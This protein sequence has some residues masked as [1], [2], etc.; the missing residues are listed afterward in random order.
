MLAD[1]QGYV[2]ADNL[3]ASRS[4]TIDLMSRLGQ[5][6]FGSNYLGNFIAQIMNDPVFTD[7]RDRSNTNFLWF[8]KF[9]RSF[10][11]S[12][13]QVKLDTRS[14][15]SKKSDQRPPVHTAQI[16]SFQNFMPTQEP[17]TKSRKKSHSQNGS[18]KADIVSFLPP[19][20]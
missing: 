17:K 14:S 13:D 10:K 7:V 16:I 3:E 6:P 5:M 9:E 20:Q 19:S 2:F 4:V 18:A 1:Y 8:I 11:D 12:E 15:D